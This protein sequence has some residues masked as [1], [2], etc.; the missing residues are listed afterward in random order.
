MYAEDEELGTNPNKAD[1]DGD[2]LSDG[3]E[4]Y[5]LGTDPLKK[6]S[7]DNGISMSNRMN[8][9]FR[10]FSIDLHAQW[11]VSLENLKD[12]IISM[13]DEDIP[14][15]LSIGD[16]DYGVGFH[17]VDSKQNNKLPVD[18]NNTDV[19]Y[20]SNHYVTITGMLEDKIKKRTYLEIS[21]WGNKYY[22]DFDEYIE[23]V[24]KHSK[25][26]FSNILYIYEVNE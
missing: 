2:K 11:E 22:I 25:S 1:S 8:E 12:C 5:A 16:S 23:Y 20:Y 9:Y 18:I 17:I 3:L 19:K 26:L 14:V 21:S 24:D 13:L 10:G 4:V 6:D 7:D 15:C